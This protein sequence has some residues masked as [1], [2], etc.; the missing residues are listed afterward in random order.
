[1]HCKICESRHDQERRSHATSTADRTMGAGPAGGVCCEDAR[2]AFNGICSSNKAGCNGTGTPA[3]P[4][5]AGSSRQARGFYHTRI[6]YLPTSSS[7]TVDAIPPAWK[8]ENNSALQSHRLCT[9]GKRATQQPGAR[10][11][12]RILSSGSST[13][14]HGSKGLTS[15]GTIAGIRRGC[16]AGQPA[17]GERLPV[18]FAQAAA[19]SVLEKQ[20]YK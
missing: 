18:N 3:N 10:P 17:T 2:H 4:F 1:M 15:P 6:C 20:S 19:R 14:Q 9:P 13:L 5:S 7:S 11:S 12:S 16:P 8:P